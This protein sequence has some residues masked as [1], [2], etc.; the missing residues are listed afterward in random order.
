MIAIFISAPS[1]LANPNNFNYE[2]EK[3]PHG[4]ESYSQDNFDSSAKMPNELRIGKNP[5][6]LEL[7]E[8]LDKT[9]DFKEISPY[10]GVGWRNYLDADQRWAFLLDVGVIFRGD[11]QIHPSPTNYDIFNVAGL[12]AK[13][14]KEDKEE[15]QTEKEN[16]ELD[17]FGFFPFLSAGILFKF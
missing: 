7:V 1:L 9:L 8:P 4:R 10:L 11:S 2:A 12:S 16:E 13:Q 17:D 5:H 14:S 15:E 6:S 3:E